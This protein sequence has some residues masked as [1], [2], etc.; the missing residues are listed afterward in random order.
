MKNYIGEIVDLRGD[1]YLNPA[2]ALYPDGGR[3]Q[4]A[5]GTITSIA[6]HHDATV[7]PHN[8]DSVARYKQEAREHYN[9][10]GPGLQY[11]FKID[12][13]GTI[14]WIRPLELWVWAVGAQENVSTIN[15]CLDGYFH[16]DVNQKPTREQYE[17]LKQLL[18]WLCTQ[19]PEFPADQNDVRPHRFYSSTACCGNTLVPFV[20]G[21]RNGLGNV[22]IPTESVYDW[23]ELQPHTE[24]P[25]VIV[26]PPVQ[27]PSGPQIVQDNGF[28]PA[29]YVAQVKTHLD[30]LETGKRYADYDPG[31]EFDFVARFTKDGTPYLLTGYAIQQHANGKR[32][33]AGVPE[34]D[35]LL[36]H[37]PST[38]TPP[39]PIDPNQEPPVVETPPDPKPE[40]QTH[41]IIKENNELLKQI[42]TLL[43]WLVDKV[44]GIFQ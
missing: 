29:T 12:N 41:E 19:H 32:E 35:I 10:L 26:E 28:V 5:V 39:S 20:D 8:Y 36:K 14:F 7:R 24:T 11:H 21:Y 9:R 23:P 4:R 18:D 15:I 43:T 31:K 34:K 25:P 37:A 44:K 17:A 27:Q 13:V 2:N 3:H 33:L 22:E 42:V 1:S 40:D 6:V 38:P 30:G 16:P